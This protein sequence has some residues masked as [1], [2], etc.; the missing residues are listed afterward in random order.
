MTA[1]R[2]PPAHLR[3]HQWQAALLLLVFL[4]ARGL[5]PAGFMPAAVTA[6][7]PYAFCHGDSRSALLLDALTQAEHAHHGGSGSHQ[8]DALTAQTFADNHCSFSASAGIATASSFES[9]PL[10]G[11]D[12]AEPP[13]FSTSLPRQRN[14][15]QPPTRAP[16]FSR[17]A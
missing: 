15:L 2:T 11:S 9:T 6:G 4:C 17:S 13:F 16:P 8:H 5:V 1:H 3:L 10:F 14:Y 12:G 7:T